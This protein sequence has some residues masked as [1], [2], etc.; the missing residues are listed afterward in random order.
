[1]VRRELIVSR[2]PSPPQAIRK[3]G[4][5]ARAF[6]H[7]VEGS[8]AFGGRADAKLQGQNLFLADEV[9]A[10]RVLASFQVG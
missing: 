7:V 6:R 9:G 2:A 4:V 3:L 10:G 5:R 8:R 1:M